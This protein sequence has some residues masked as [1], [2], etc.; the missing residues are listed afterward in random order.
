MKYPFTLTKAALIA[1]TMLFSTVTSHAGNAPSFLVVGRSYSL[2]LNGNKQFT[3][4]EIGREGWVRV[5]FQSH[6]EIAWINTNA[7][8]AISFFPRQVR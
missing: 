3:V 2:F 7:I 4:L 5:M 8:G 1:V 6:N